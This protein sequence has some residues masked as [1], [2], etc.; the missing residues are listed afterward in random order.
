MNEVYLKY[1][2]FEN[3]PVRTCIG[4]QSLPLNGKFEIDCIAIVPWN[5]QLNYY[6]KT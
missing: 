4:V 2:N 1:F 5:K 3:K 6:F